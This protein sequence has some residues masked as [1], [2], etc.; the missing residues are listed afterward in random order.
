MKNQ[1]SLNWGEIKSNLEGYTP[2]ELE[3]YKKHRDGI[4]EYINN[5]EGEAREFIKER[6]EILDTSMNDF[7]SNKSIINLFTSLNH[8]GKTFSSAIQL[9]DIYLNEVYGSYTLYGFT[10][11]N[12]P[13][14]VFR[15]HQNIII[16][17][18]ADVS[19]PIFDKGYIEEEYGIDEDVLYDIESML[20]YKASIYL[21]KMLEKADIISLLTNVRLKYPV[22]LCLDTSDQ[23]VDE[24]GKGQALLKIEK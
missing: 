6:L 9:F 24:A 23:E 8:K 17:G 5:Y 22:Y 2:E 19:E 1:E 4:I 21:K 15:E 7:L 14:E 16:E 12:E 20:S 3:V 10:D 11:Y 18:Y 13:D